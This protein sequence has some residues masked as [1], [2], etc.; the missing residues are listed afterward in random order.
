VTA[1]GIVVAV[2]APRAHWTIDV[3]AGLAVAIAVGLLF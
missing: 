2:I 1:A 3:V